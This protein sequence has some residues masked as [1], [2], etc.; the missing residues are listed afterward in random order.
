MRFIARNIK[1]LLLQLLVILTAVTVLIL[2]FFYLY[3]PTTTNHGETLTVPNLIGLSNEEL[4]EYLI[5]RNLRYEVTQDSSYSSKFPP[6]AILQQD[7]KPNAKVKEN[8]KI[9]ITLNMSRPPSTKMPCLIDGSIKNA[10]AVL[11]SHDLLLGDIKYRPALGLNSVLAQRYQGREFTTCKEIDKGID[12]PKG[13]KIDLI[14][15]NG[16]G[17]ITFPVPNLIGLSLEEAKFIMIGS[18]LK[19]GSTIYGKF[20]YLVEKE[21]VQQAIGIGNQIELGTIL[22]QKPS[23][24]Q[25]I[26]I[27]QTINLW[28]WGSKEEYIQKLKKDSLAQY[29]IG[30]NYEN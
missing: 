6:Q 2:L 22:D 10:Q 4:D 25:Q 21:E 19:V 28:V 13:S 15:A 9:Y 7:P 24:D 8:R 16:F 23:P 11:R 3:L 29:A 20:Q 14:A 18:G 5:K 27:G 30:L 17:R 1:E 12:I 26:K